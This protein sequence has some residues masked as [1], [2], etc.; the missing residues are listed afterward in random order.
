MKWGI[1]LWISW[2]VN[3]NWDNMINVVDFFFYIT[4]LNG[5]E[6]KKDRGFLDV[7]LL[8]EYLGEL[9]FVDSFI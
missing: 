5:F 6:W 9:M 2:K 7:F 4:Y 3:G 1:L 8:K